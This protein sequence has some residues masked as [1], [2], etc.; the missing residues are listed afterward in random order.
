M[1]K[2]DLIKEVPSA[3]IGHIGFAGWLVNHC[4]PK[5]TVDLGVDYGTST[6]SFA[7]PNIGMVYGI[8]CFEGDAHTGIRQTLPLVKSKAKELDL[9]NILLIKGYF[10]DVAESWTQNIDILH[11]DGFHEYLA[12]KNDFN[13]WSRFLN[14][15]GVILLHDTRVEHFGVK[16]FFQEIDWPKINFQ[17]S[18][19]LGIVSKNKTLL[20]TICDTFTGTQSQELYYNNLRTV[21][22]ECVKYF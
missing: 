12:V 19:G 18:A 22:V 5:V 4:Q 9:G 20:N 7:V 11:I 10:N 2:I 8:D 16:D 1:N 21:T 6:F 14:N 3:W 13:T 17:H 15:D